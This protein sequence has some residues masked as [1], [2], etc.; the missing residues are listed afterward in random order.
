MKT[1]ILLPCIILSLAVMTLAGCG[2]RESENST[3]STTNSAADQATPGAADTNNATPPPAASPSDTN[4]PATGNT[5]TN[6]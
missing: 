6:Q 2:Q 5:T 3:P 4:S 1:K